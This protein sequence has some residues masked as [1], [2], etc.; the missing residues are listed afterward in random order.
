MRLNGLIGQLRGELEKIRLGSVMNQST[1]NLTGTISQ[2]Q[3]ALAIERE[4]IKE[5]DKEK[6]S[7]SK[8]ILDL[9]RQV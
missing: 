4:N 5:G 8:E 9:R 3:A 2:L 6:E 1:E 7:M